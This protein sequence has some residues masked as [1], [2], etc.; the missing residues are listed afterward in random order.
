MIYVAIYLLAIVDANLLIAWLGPSYM[1]IVGFLFIGLDFTSRDKIHDV[2]NGRGLV[3]KMGLLIA[4]G[5]LITYLL[6]RNAG[7]IAVASFAA[8]AFAALLDTFFY[9]LML[10]DDY[11]KR[12]NTSNFIASIADSFVFPTIAFGG[13]MPLAIFL[14]LV[15]K[16]GGGFLWSLIL[17]N[18]KRAGQA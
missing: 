15:A 11:I 14:Q 12:V 8:F 3:W 16:I 1:P 9:H 7:Q 10:D 17:Q 6:N 4:S 13:F 2:W 5:S 18:R